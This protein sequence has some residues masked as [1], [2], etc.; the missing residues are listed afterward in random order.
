MKN[1]KRAK[2]KVEKIIVNQVYGG[3]KHFCIF[4][5]VNSLNTKNKLAESKKEFE[6]IYCIQELS[7]F[8]D[9][10][11]KTIDEHKTIE[12]RIDW[13]NPILLA[14][15]NL[16]NIDLKNHKFLGKRILY[17]TDLEGPLSDEWG[18]IRVL[19]D[20]LNEAQCYLYVVGPDVEISQTIKHSVTDRRT[21]SNKDNLSK[22]ALANV[23][24]LELILDESYGLICNLD[25][26]VELYLFYHCFKTLQGLKE[27]LEIENVLEIQVMTT[28]FI[29]DSEILKIKRGNF[30]RGSFKFVKNTIDEN[31]YENEVNYCNVTEGFHCGEKFIPLTKDLLESF[32]TSTRKIFRILGFVSEN[33]LEEYYF[34]DEKTNFVLPQENSI[35]TYVALVNTLLEKKKYAIA[36]RNYRSCFEAHLVVLI[37]LKDTKVLIM[38]DIPFKSDVVMDWTIQLQKTYDQCEYDHESTVILTD[39]LNAI[40]VDTYSCSE[41]GKAVF[42]HEFKLNPTKQVTLRKLHALNSEKPILDEHSNVEDLLYDFYPKNFD[43]NV[44]NVKRIFQEIKTEKESN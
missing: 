6:N 44:Q 35:N 27:V 10:V 42:G 31:A 2:E 40:R 26:A 38:S 36:L 4:Y 33:D 41:R 39:Y 29:K 3:T 1:R 18:S 28:T 9:E 32:K 34:C 24:K 20:A 11:I 13:T 22:N 12:D 30:Q 17:F 37:P 16:I 8:Q 23:E 7:Y 25:V 5:L 19:S 43:E 14:V 15:H 21:L